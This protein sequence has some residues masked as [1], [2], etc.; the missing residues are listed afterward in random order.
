MCQ[1][2][3]YSILMTEKQIPMATLVQGYG[4]R[5]VD[6]N[7][8]SRRQDLSTTNCRKTL[9]GEYDPMDELER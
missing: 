4:P 9:R 8:D 3:L 5:G 2:G 6:P 1:V 7:D